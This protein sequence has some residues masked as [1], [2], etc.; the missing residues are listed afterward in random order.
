M[1]CNEFK[2]LISDYI[3]GMLDADNTHSLLEHAESCAECRRILDD[4]REMHSLLSSA[5]A[6]PDEFSVDVFEKIR[7]QKR[8][9]HYLK[10]GWISGIAVAC[11]TVCVLGASLL[12]RAG[13]PNLADKNLSGSIKEEYTKEAFESVVSENEAE[14]IDGVGTYNNAVFIPLNK[15]EK[16]RDSIIARVAEEDYEEDEYAIYISNASVYEEELKKCLGDD[17]PSDIDLKAI[18]VLEIYNY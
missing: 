16:F 12:G 3:D 9:K 5:I 1:N 15:Y 6:V 7:N 2:N 10:K 11:L 18:E 17:Y 4:Y 13:K 8:K 14:I